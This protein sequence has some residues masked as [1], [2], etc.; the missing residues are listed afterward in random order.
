[1]NYLHTNDD[2]E[3]LLPT[4][5]DLTPKS[6]DQIYDDVLYP[7][8]QPSGARTVDLDDG[9]LLPP[10]VKENQEDMPPLLDS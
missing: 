4:G 10:W 9:P 2:E 6:P 7:T 3:I 5:V 1:M 8:S